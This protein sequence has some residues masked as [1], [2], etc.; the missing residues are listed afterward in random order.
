M[1]GR[2][3]TLRGPGLAAAVLLACL[4]AGCGGRA[5]AERGSRTLQ[6]FVSIP[7]QAYLAKRVGG[8]RVEVH[9][10][11]QPG[12]NPH[13]FNPTP[14]QVSMLADSDLYFTVGIG[15][16]TRIVERLS[17]YQG[18]SVVDACRNIERRSMA[19]PLS[20]RT[21]EGKK[22]PHTW[23]DPLLAA[24]QARNMC[25]A[26]KRQDAA[27]AE[28]YE[29]NIA[30][31]RDDLERLNREVRAIL[32]PVRGR[33]MFVFHPAYG[34]FADRYGLH[35]VP[36]QQ[37]GSTPGAR[38]LSQ[39][40]KKGRKE[41]VEAIFVQPQYSARQA[42]AVAGAVGAEVVPLDPLAAD[43]PS[44]L[45][46]MARMVRRALGPEDAPSTGGRNE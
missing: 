3:G 24:T 34:Y 15:L 32:E 13:T 35:Q 30:A 12:D 19:D 11:L 31:L 16:E 28:F 14:K 9:T 33:R 6:V 37:A 21:H 26:M 10:L 29:K 43:Y 17:R 38:H 5:P 45:K 7:P 1:N 8:N 46:R 22:D 25:A 18:L 27:N 36:V 2:D 20:G 41:N 42:R 39:I 23:L 40:I 44:N 4:L